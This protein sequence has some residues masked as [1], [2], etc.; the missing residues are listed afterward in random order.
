VKNLLAGMHTVRFAK[1]MAVTT[2]VDQS[3]DSLLP[4]KGYLAFG[5]VVEA[6]VSHVSRSFHAGTTH[7]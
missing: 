5:T 7:A 1:M 3:C 6:F 2:S 4:G